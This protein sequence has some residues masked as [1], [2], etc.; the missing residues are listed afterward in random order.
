[1]STEVGPGDQQGPPGLVRLRG[2]HLLPVDHPLVAVPHG[3][4]SQRGQ[5]AARARLA[6]QLA[7]D[8]LGRPEL[9]QPALF[10]LVGAVGEDGRGGHAQ[11]DTVTLGVVGR[12]AGRGELGVDDRLQGP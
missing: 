5:V 8:F 7:P 1:M 11:A 10:L 9:A 3:P 4:G 2:P 6:E 12:G